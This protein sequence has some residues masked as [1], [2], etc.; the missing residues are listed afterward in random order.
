MAAANDKVKHEI[1]DSFNMREDLRSIIY[2]GTDAEIEYSLKLLLQL[3]FE[4]RVAKD[5]AD[6][7]DLYNKIVELEKISTSD[8]IKKNCQGNY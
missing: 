8:R 4:K 7:H 5:V 2:N 3:C 6:D 1:Y